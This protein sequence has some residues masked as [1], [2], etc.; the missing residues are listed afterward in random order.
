MPGRVF[1]WT[2][3]PPR[4]CLDQM[5]PSSDPDD[6]KRDQDAHLVEHHPGWKPTSAELRL[7]SWDEGNARDRLI[8]NPTTYA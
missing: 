2:C 4:G 7:S 1:W 5:R 8:V 6:V 3:P